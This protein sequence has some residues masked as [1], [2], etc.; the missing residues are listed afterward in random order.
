MRTKLLLN[1]IGHS[2]TIFCNNHVTTVTAAPNGVYGL[3]NVFH[4]LHSNLFDD[5]F[6]EKLNKIFHNFRENSKSEQQI[7]ERER[8]RFGCR[9]CDCRESFIQISV[10]SLSLS[11]SITQSSFIFLVLHGSYRAFFL[12]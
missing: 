12:H 8:E 4:P 11:P 1:K 6:R 3:E 9:S 2:K 5:L 10:S 7:S